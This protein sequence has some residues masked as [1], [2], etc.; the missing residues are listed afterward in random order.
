MKELNDT[1]LALELVRHAYKFGELLNQIQFKIRTDG[2]PILN[3]SE[4]LDFLY[5]K[6]PDFCKALKEIAVRMER[7]AIV[8]VQEEIEN[9]SR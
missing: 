9:D 1:E 5:E 2:H 3:E 7:A 4:N 8:I 6:G